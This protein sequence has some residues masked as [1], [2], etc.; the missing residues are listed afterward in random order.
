[1]FTNVA[2]ILGECVLGNKLKT[3]DTEWDM[4]H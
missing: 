2:C 4:S 3:I 1:M